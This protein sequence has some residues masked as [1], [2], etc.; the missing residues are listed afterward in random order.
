VTLLV[1]DGTPAQKSYALPPSSRTNVPIALDFPEAQGRRFGGIVDSTGASQAQ[2]VV[3][4]AIYGDAGGVVWA[5]GS[6]ALGTR[7]P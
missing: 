6:N 1:E 4:R 5:A 7:I 2:I 3:E